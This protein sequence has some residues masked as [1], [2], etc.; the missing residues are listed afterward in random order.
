[1]TLLRVESFN[2]APAVKRVAEPCGVTDRNSDRQVSRLPAR[3]R[4]RTAKSCNGRKK[5]ANG[6]HPPSFRAVKPVRQSEPDDS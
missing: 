2:S 5:T 1:M 6:G 3:P 4:H